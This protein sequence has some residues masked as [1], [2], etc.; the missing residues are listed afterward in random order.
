MREELHGERGTRA[1]L[2]SEGEDD[3]SVRL[4]ETLEAVQVE[5]RRA[6]KEQ[7]KRTAH[8]EGQVHNLSTCTILVASCC[9]LGDPNKSCI[10]VGGRHDALLHSTRSHGM[11][12]Y[13]WAVLLATAQLPSP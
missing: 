12:L 6:L 7:E 11:L 8:L 5:L 4:N 13:S 1:A 10:I 9:M 3:G 2:G